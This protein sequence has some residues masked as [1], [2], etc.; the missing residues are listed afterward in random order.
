VVLREAS[1]L[2]KLACGFVDCGDGYP[3]VLWGSTPIKTFMNAH[4]R[5][6]RTSATSTRRTFRL[7]ALLP[8]LFWVTPRASGTGGTQA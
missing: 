3:D 7:W 8:Y 5:F 1:A 4:L 2:E 6:R